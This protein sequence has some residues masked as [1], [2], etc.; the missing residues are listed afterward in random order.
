MVSGVRIPPRPQL[1]QK[2][3]TFP[4]RGRKIMIG[5][6][7][8]KLWNLGVGLLPKLMTASLRHLLVLVHLRILN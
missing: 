2:G 6:A 1:A 8:P 3:R 4:S 5:I 7:D